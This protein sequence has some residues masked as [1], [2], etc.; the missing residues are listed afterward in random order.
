[1]I[2]ISITE[3]RRNFSKIIKMIKYESKGFL[4]TDKRRNKLV[5]KLTPPDKEKM[6]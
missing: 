1:M 4:I 5:A 3:L 2:I 6:D